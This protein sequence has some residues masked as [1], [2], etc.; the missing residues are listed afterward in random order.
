M[1]KPLYRRYTTRVQG[2]HSEAL[3][4]L[5][6]TFAIRRIRLGEN[7]Q[8]TIFSGRLL[9]EARRENVSDMGTCILCVPLMKYSTPYS[10]G[11]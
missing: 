1:A 11:W 4:L 8:S 3:P 7:H 10:T 2:R 9:Q 6:R 5:E